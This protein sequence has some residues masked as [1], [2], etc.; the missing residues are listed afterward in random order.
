MKKFIIVLSVTI[1]W[2]IISESQPVTVHCKP[3]QVFEVCD[4]TMTP[5]KPSI[6]SLINKKLNKDYI[7]TKGILIDGTIESTN[8]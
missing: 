7:I 3:K 6:L 1:V 2:N 5:P 8:S 4:C